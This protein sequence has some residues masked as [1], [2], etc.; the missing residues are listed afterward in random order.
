MSGVGRLT[1]A[2]GCSCLELVLEESSVRGINET[3]PLTPSRA[4]TGYSGEHRTQAVEA[5]FN[6]HMVKPVKPDELERLLE[7][8]PTLERHPTV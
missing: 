5:G 2:L 6:L 7:Q 8:L 4:L 1:R 3:I